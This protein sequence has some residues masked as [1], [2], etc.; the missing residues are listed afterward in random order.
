M[1]QHGTAPRENSPTGQTI[2]TPT[3]SYAKHSGTAWALGG[4]IFAGVL[5]TVSGIMGILNGIAGIAGDDVYTNIGDY[6]F[7]F[8]LYT[9]GWIHLAIGVVV[10][11]TGWSIL[12]GKDWARGMGIAL[13]SLFAIEYFMF[14][15]YAP[16]WS[17][18]AIAIAVFVM[19]SLATSHDHPATT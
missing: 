2:S 10:A 1:A 19:W 12:Q 6:V 15:P 7:E 16:V 4:T 17:I 11:F 9:W 14:L 8:S 13:A 18:I 3:P 5:M